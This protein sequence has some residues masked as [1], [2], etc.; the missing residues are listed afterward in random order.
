M[1]LKD[2]FKKD[3][4]YYGWVIDGDFTMDTKKHFTKLKL[5]LK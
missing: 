3:P 1:L 2:V 4:G 5:E